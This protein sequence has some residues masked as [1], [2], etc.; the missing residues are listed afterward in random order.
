MIGDQLRRLLCW[1]ERG[2]GAAGCSETGSREGL[3]EVARRNF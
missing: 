3:A 2:R 1:T